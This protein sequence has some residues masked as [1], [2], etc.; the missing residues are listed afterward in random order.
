[1]GRHEFVGCLCFFCMDCVAWEDVVVTQRGSSIGG[2]GRGG[3]FEGMQ[4]R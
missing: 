3:G 1:M 4:H 2:G